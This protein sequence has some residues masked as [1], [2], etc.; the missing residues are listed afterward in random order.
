[1]SEC[2]NYKTK[3]SFFRISRTGC[4]GI[5]LCNMKK[6]KSISDFKNQGVRMS[7]NKQTYMSVIMFQW[8]MYEPHS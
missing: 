8:K 4:V 2:R 3:S 5:L 1:M 6:K 7:E